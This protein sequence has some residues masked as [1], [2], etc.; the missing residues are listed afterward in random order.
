M[1]GFHLRFDFGEARAPSRRLPL[2]AASTP[3]SDREG[4][5][6]LLS[7][8]DE[9]PS[10][11][12]HK[13]TATSTINTISTAVT[14]FN[15]G[16]S[17]PKAQTFT[18]ADPHPKARPTIADPLQTRRTL[19][20]IVDQA[21]ALAAA[22]ESERRRD[23]EARKA[24]TS[25]RKRM[26]LTSSDLHDGDDGDD[27][28]DEDG[29]HES[30]VASKRKLTRGSSHRL[31]ARDSADDDDDDDD[32]DDDDSPVWRITQRPLRKTALTRSTTRNEDGPFT[33]SKY[34]AL[35]SNR[36]T[37]RSQARQSRVKV[38]ENLNPSHLPSNF[39][40]NA[41]TNLPANVPAAS[42]PEATATAQTENDAPIANRY[43]A[44]SRVFPSITRPVGENDAE[45][46]EVK[47]LRDE[48][49][50][51]WQEIADRLNAARVAAGQAPVLTETAVYARYTRNAEHIAS[52]QREEHWTT[53]RHGYG[54]GLDVSQPPPTGA[55]ALP[56]AAT[57]HP[58]TSS[59][60]V[61]STYHSL[62]SSSAAQN[63]AVPGPSKRHIF[64]TADDAMLAR[65]HAEIQAE[66]WDLVAQR[67]VRLGG[68]SLDPH[69]CAR[70]FRDMSG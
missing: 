43:P 4:G 53:K 57:S 48:E 47:R 42:R 34:H 21:R 8:S 38:E 68:P 37:T 54:H 69:L 10:T 40:S 1:S 59:S 24:P 20:D 3:D 17:T 63:E 50:Y 16:A 36:P 44:R 7:L 35:P 39:P 67:L 15:A 11:S 62:V 45:N 13:T 41:S 31:H 61:S 28:D 19:I 32:G 27:G 14:T 5:E 30:V 12:T 23:E 25:K 49:G 56:S 33:P 26:P 46:Q 65:A 9:E 2:D 18:V 51:K 29:V 60:P 64:T 52:A 55:F 58:V 6:W 66:R 22:E 70:R